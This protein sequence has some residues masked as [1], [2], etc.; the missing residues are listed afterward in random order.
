MPSDRSRRTDDLRD[1][2]KEVVAQQGR[3]ILDRDFNALQGLADERIAADALDIVGPR[4]TPDDGFAISLPQTSPQGLPLWSPPGGFGPAGAQDFDFLISPGTMYVGGQR[5]VLPDHQFG[6][7]ITY[8]YYDQPDWVDPSDPVLFESP[9]GYRELVYLDLAEQEVS[10]VEDP[11]LLEVALGG[12]DTTGRIKLMRRI[13]REAVVDSDCADARQEATK[14]WLERDGLRLDPCT[15]RLEPVARLQVSFTQDATTGDPCDPVATGGYLG[16]DNQ[17][18]RVQISHSGRLGAGAEEARLLWGYDNASFLYRITSVSSDGTMLTLAAD[19]PDAFHIPQ[20]GQL[21][22]VLRTTAVLGQEPDETAPAGQRSILRVVAA[23]TGELRRLAKPYGSITTGDPTKYIVLKTPLDGVYAASTTPLFLRV[24]QAELAFNPAGDTVALNDESSGASTGIEVTISLAQGEVATTGAYWLLAVRPSTPQAVY[25]ERLLTA[26]Q[27]PDGP[28]RWVCPLAVIDWQAGTVADCRCKFDNL[29]ALTK[30]TR[31][32]CTV[33]VSPEQLTA[34]NTLQSILDAATAPTGRAEQVTVCLAPGSYVLHQPLR[35]NERH[36][37]VTIES[38]G[39]AATI[40][41]SG[42]GFRDGLVVLTGVEG[43]TLRGLNIIPQA[44]PLPAALFEPLLAGL[45]RCVV[46]EAVEWVRDFARVLVD[47]LRARAAIGVRAVNGSDLIIEN[48]TVELTDASEADYFGIGVFASGDCGGLTV[49]GCSF[50]ATAAPTSTPGVVQ[51]GGL[52]EP[53]FTFQSEGRQFRRAAIGC[54]VSPYVRGFPDPNPN[55]VEQFTLPARLDD[56]SFSN[57]TFER[58]TLAVSVMA[59]IGSMRL[60]GNTIASSIGGFWIKTS[61]IQE[62]RFS[63]PSE[64]IAPK[65][66]DGLWLDLALSN[67]ECFVLLFLGLTYPMPVGARAGSQQSAGPATIF[68]SDNQ[69]TALP[70]DDAAAS[71]CALA[72]LTGPSDVQTDIGAAL[73]VSANRLQGRPP[74]KYPS[75]L[76]SYSGRCAATG[77]LISAEPTRDQKLATSLLIVPEGFRNTGTVE[78]KQVILAPHL[79]A[80]GNVLEPGNILEGATNLGELVR[81]EVLASPFNVVPFNSG[82]MMTW[83]Y[84]NAT[85]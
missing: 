38:C 60:N 20:A 56:A 36:W 59:D 23:A 2:Y 52:F 41:G 8:G 83:L 79:A 9:P 57:N 48:C 35:L 51:P 33:S 49:R 42:P 17:L 34:A 73:A 27:P 43:I 62:F 71:T 6:Q 80:S 7:A 50:T 54:L 84:W 29:V 40:S 18:I 46:S 19:P 1:G 28:R 75:V 11:D 25:P 12:P 66:G 53:E 55:G 14:R 3:V 82:P 81:P 30:R 4:G 24:W 61:E 72:V 77:N 63:V 37:G 15:M 31:S 47:G 67:Q 32:C 5:A 44:V 78:G 26:P 70:S 74:V 68:I 58:V 45:E 76:L 21:V 69:V 10:A 22:E 16:A 85:A 64:K 13:K 65:D 39:G